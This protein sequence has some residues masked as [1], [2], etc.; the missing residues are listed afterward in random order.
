[1]VYL[2]FIFERERER[3]RER[4][5]NPGRDREKERQNPKQGLYQQHR[6][7]CGA[8]IQIMTWAKMK[9]QM[10]NPLHHPRYCGT[11]SK[12][13]VQMSFWCLTYG[14]VFPK[15]ADLASAYYNVS[16][17]GMWGYRC[18]KTIQIVS[19]GDQLI[20]LLLKFSLI[21]FVARALR[22]LF[23]QLP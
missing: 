6:A 14:F 7:L 15:T 10:L 3:E 13:T 22:F 23:F 8:W 11:L 1:M 16:G 4:A 5:S 9:S 18:I 17:L 20:P 2:L 21:T 19:S 12:G